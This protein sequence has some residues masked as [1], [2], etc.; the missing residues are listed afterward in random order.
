MTEIRHF[1]DLDR[2]DGSLL[3]SLIESGKAFKRGSG[4]PARPLEGKTLAMIFEKPSTRTRVSFEAGM[5]RTTPS[6]AAA[7]PSP[8]PPACCRA[9]STRS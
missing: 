3:R 2:V 8:I 7:R 6:W 4:V 1:L 9:M 5:P